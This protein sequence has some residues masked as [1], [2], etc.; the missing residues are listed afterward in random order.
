MREQTWRRQMIAEDVPDPSVDQLQ[1][2]GTSAPGIFDSLLILTTGA[3]CLI[4]FAVYW[5]TG[6]SQTLAGFDAQPL[7]IDVPIYA[8]YQGSEFHWLISKFLHVYAHAMGYFGIASAA[9]TRKLPYALMG[10]GNLGLAILCFALTFRSW[11]WR[12]LPFAVAY[13]FSFTVWLF[14][15]VPECYMLN[16]LLATGYIATLLWFDRIKRSAGVALAAAAIYLLALLN[17]ASGALLGLIPLTLYGLRSVREPSL[18]RAFGYHIGAI[19]VFAGLHLAINA[20]ANYVDLIQKY[21][22]F[23]DDAGGRGFVLAIPLMD[24][25]FHAIGAPDTHTSFAAVKSLPGYHGFFTPRLS[26]YF[27]NWRSAA[28][29]LLYLPMWFTLRPNRF[30]RFQVALLA[31]IFARLL[32]PIAFNPT[33]SIIYATPSILPI[34]LLL[35]GGT[36]EKEGFWYRAWPWALAAAIVL[37]NG[38]LLGLA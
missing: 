13:A 16:T 8:N 34:W 2:S 33:E 32:Y 27:S 22:P 38:P 14:A 4:A 21:S 26:E 37:A 1:T 25:F 10:A 30:D 20:H 35:A 11:A 36:V 9:L 5:A 28:F 7:G 19:A 15:H 24:F 31:F 29:L 12:L 3:F 17:D 6:I 23:F 18:R